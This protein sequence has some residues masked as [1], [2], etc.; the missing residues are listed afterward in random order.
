MSNSRRSFLKT[1]TAASVASTLGNTAIFSQAY[2]TQIS[3]RYGT[4]TTDN[5]PGSD[6][7][8]G[9]VGDEVTSKFYYASSDGTVFKYMANGYLTWALALSY[10][11][12]RIVANQAASGATV[13]DHFTAQVDACISAKVTDIVLM[14]GQ[15]DL[16]QS[17]SLEDLK[18][19]WTTV[20][21]RAS[22]GAQ[23][24]WWLTQT[25]L[26]SSATGATQAIRNAIPALNTWILSEASKYA[27]VVA[28]DVTTPVARIAADNFTSWIYPYSKDNVTPINVAAFYIGR[29][30]ATK[31]NAAISNNFEL[32]VDPQDDIVSDPR[33]VN[34]VHNSLFTEGLGVSS[35]D[36]LSGGSGYSNSGFDLIFSGGSGTGGAIAKAVV[37][38]GVVTGITII[39]PGNYT[40]AP[41]VS[42]ANGGGSGAAATIKLGPAGYAN[43][44]RGNVTELV[45]HPDG[46]SYGKLA[47]L[48]VTFPN[49]QN[50]S[51]LLYNYT[52][53]RDI[54]K[55]L[56]PKDVFS[57]RCEVHRDALSDNL[58]AC[59]PSITMYKANGGRY[60][61]SCGVSTD[62]EVLPADAQFRAVFQTPPAVVGD[63][64]SASLMLYVANPVNYATGTTATVKV[65]RFSC[66]V[67]PSVTYTRAD[68]GVVNF[69]PGHYL[70]VYADWAYGHFSSQDSFET[71]LIETT[72]SPG[73]TAAW[74]GIE[75]PW[76]WK[77]LEPSKG[78]YQLEGI[79]KWLDALRIYKNKDGTPVDKYLL[80]YLLTDSYTAPAANSFPA[81]ILTDP[82][83]GGGVYEHNNAQGYKT[84]Y[85]NP[86]IQDRLILLAQ[87]I[88]ERFDSDPV[89]EGFRIDET[90]AG[91][92]L[93]KVLQKYNSDYQKSVTLT[94][95]V[96]GQVR[97]A[98]EMNKA[99][100]QSLFT[101]GFNYVADQK[102][103]RVARMLVQAG[104]GIGAVDIIQ[105]EPTLAG[106]YMSYDIIKSTSRFVP[107]LAHFDAGNYMSN[108][109]TIQ[110]VSTV[111]DFAAT[112]LNASHISWYRQW[113]SQL[114]NNYRQL[115]TYFNG[116]KSQAD[117]QSA[118]GCTDGLNT[119]LPE[120]IS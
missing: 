35:F 88:A 118:V 83:Y 4:V 106:Q 93:A 54:I 61:H 117:W 7:T 48:T 107:S 110:D 36:T 81:Y 97:I 92:T 29:A 27:N 26:N 76:Y 41:D 82:E 86:Y 8:L 45:S 62:D 13:K 51:G 120:S 24:V 6:N 15:N 17:T 22:A 101:I 68:K 113:P 12:L 60:Y 55:H 21:A 1:V 10:Q 38:N 102:D 109:S 58:A 49:Y 43:I 32:A 112:H 25:P 103:T 71:S 79:Q 52:M 53:N 42:F 46:A 99:F 56:G 77:D 18:A 98:V 31:W 40:A 95:Y 96:E 70:N 34:I 66:L 65:G 33:S 85:D 78:D 105:I 100:K 63:M 37:T 20:I 89:F 74:R 19:A 28:I 64:N 5:I 69:H 57:V 14:G 90:S 39:N 16:R 87:K 47:K 111:T 30:I 94:D 84:R 2:A 11:R 9:I 104:V 73:T 115:V 116:K 23:R 119:V 72:T 3:T 75:R 50:Y 59:G 114:P 44:D 67:Q 108:G 91:D 80:V